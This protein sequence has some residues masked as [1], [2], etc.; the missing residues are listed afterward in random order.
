MDIVVLDPKSFIKREVVMKQIDIM[1]KRIELLENKVEALEMEVIIPKL[2]C[3]GPGETCEVDDCCP[4]SPCTGEPLCGCDEPHPT[5]AG[6]PDD[7]E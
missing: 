6:N 7:G 5:F 1:E 4:D 3:D 2:A